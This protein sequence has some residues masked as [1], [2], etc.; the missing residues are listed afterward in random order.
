MQC[1][2]SGNLQLI[3][4]HVTHVPALLAQLTS[5]GLTLDGSKFLSR[6]HRKYRPCCEN[7]KEGNGSRGSTCGADS[8]HL[9]LSTVKVGTKFHN[10]VLD[11]SG[12]LLT[13]GVDSAHVII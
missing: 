4:F 12:N 8:L 3:S 1:S 7:R 9:L 6:M 11:S 13:I 2:K 5:L 10:V